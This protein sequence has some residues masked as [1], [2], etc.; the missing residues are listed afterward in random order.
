MNKKE[1]TS[2]VSG[3]TGRA[4]KEVDKL[5][6]ALK[7]AV[8]EA[9]YAGKTVKLPGIGTFSSHLE[10]EKII[11]D[12]TLGQSVLYPPCVTIDFKMADSLINKLN[13]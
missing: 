2:A 9:L 12:K 3:I 13:K 4:D 6:E 7:I 11:E 5:L 1:F 8:S 10:D